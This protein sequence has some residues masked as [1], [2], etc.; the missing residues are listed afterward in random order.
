MVSG[1]INA[2]PERYDEQYGLFCSL[3]KFI[4]REYTEK[5]Y[6]VLKFCNRER[7]AGSSRDQ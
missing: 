6:E 4:E 5:D 7:R 3:C 2:N 1:T